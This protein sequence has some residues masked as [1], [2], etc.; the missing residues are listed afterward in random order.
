MGLRDDVRHRRHEKIKMLLEEYAANQEGGGRPASA[1]EIDEMEQMQRQKDNQAWLAKKKK[2]EEETH[3]VFPPA[4]S[5]LADRDSVQS[6]SPDPELAWKRNPNP[7]SSWGEVPAHSSSQRSFVRQ[8]RTYDDSDIPPRGGWSRFRRGLQWK[9]I[10]ALIIFGGIYG[11]FHYE[12]D[13][14]ERGQQ[15]VKQA[16]TDEFDFAA[17][18]VWYKQAFAGAPSFIP[19]FQGDSR[20]AVGVDGGVSGT[21]AVPIEHASLIR[22]FAELLNGVE[23]AGDSEAPV[24]AVET[25]RVIMETEEQVL[26]QHANNRITIYGKLGGSDVSVNDWVEAGDPIGKL[27]EAGENG[28]SLLYFGVKQDDR[29]MD[30]LDV[31]RLD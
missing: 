12:A 23:L 11:M 19:M 9:T 21:I 3:L 30:P 1:G 29:Y 5:E 7:W 8:T 27:K 4:P 13:W 2:T 10:A 16:L 18:A 31:I 28:Q 24:M 6:Q 17:A 20:G 14:A 22:T 15:I 25:G 26:I